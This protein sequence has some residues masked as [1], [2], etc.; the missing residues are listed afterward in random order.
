MD[1]WMDPLNILRA[2]QICYRSTGQP[3][4]FSRPA[5]RS[6]EDSKAF[7]LASSPKMQSSFYIDPQQT[8]YLL[9]FV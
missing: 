3:A 6:N 2:N 1:G 4:L 5:C 8:S 7:S 9:I